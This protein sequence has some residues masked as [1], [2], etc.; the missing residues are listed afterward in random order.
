LGGTNGVAT[1]SGPNA[2]AGAFAGVSDFAGAAGGL[3]GGDPVYGSA[4]AHAA[5]QDGIAFTPLPPIQLTSPVT[6]LSFGNAPFMW[7]L[8]AALDVLLVGLTVVLVRR[9]LSKSAVD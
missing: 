7:P 8:F 6:G 3:T 4:A 1:G 5:S 2:P 9:T